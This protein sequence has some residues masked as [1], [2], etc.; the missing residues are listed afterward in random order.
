MPSMNHNTRSK[1][2]VRRNELLR[3]LQ[4]VLDCF[5]LSTS[6]PKDSD[7]GELTG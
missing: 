6:D 2:M 4:M 3:V 7:E 5:R 1:L